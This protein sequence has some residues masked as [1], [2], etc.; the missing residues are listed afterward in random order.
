MKQMLLLLSVATSAARASSAGFFQGGWSQPLMMPADLVSL[1]GVN[2]RVEPGD[3]DPA[4]LLLPKMPWDLGT[5][6]AGGAGTVLW[7]PGAQLYKCW[8][9]ASPAVSDAPYSPAGGPD[10]GRTLA[11][12]T[13]SDGT[14][15]VRPKLTLFPYGNH[16][17][18]NIVL[19]LPD[20]GKGEG[21][22]QY[23]SVN[24]NLE[25]GTPPPKRYEMFV[26]ISVSNDETTS[27]CNCMLYASTHSSAP[28]Q[29]S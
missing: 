28:Q 29:R 23:A 24:L 27:Y 18:T 26:V 6:G 8:Y 11:Y 2:W 20:S 15:W 5:V 13:S 21:K 16:S 4:P 22:V 1:H 17:R 10:D 7:D 25:P 9:V 12:A 3:V 14:R 19:A